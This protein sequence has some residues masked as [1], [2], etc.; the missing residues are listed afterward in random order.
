MK[1]KGK[2]NFSFILNISFI[3]ISSSS[4]LWRNSKAGRPE[5]TDD[6]GSRIKFA[7]G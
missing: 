6:G 5:N 2:M 1:W 3:K 7:G 4:E